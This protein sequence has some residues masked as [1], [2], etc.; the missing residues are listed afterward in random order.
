MNASVLSS[1]NILNNEYY[2]SKVV[3]ITNIFIKR[4]SRLCINVIILWLLM[5]THKNLPVKVI[6]TRAISTRAISLIFPP[7]KEKGCNSYY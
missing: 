7:I 3:Q 1:N 6:S 5:V 4:F 2:S